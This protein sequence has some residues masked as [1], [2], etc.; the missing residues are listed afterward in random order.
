MNH[1]KLACIACLLLIT[2]AV[3][4]QQTPVIS[5]TL[6]SGSEGKFESAPDTALVQF[7]ISLQ[8]ARLQD[9]YAQARESAARIRQIIR[10]NGLA[11]GDA[12]IGSF[13]MTPVYQWNAK[14]K[15]IGFQVNSS[16]VVKVHEFEKLGP[17]SD[18]FS[19]LDTSDGFSISFTLRNIE[20]AK[21]KAIEDGYRKA[22]SNAE[23]LAQAGGRKL[24][25]MSYASVDASEFI[26]QPRPVIMKAQLL[27]GHTEPAP[28]QGFTPA[29]IIITAH[30]NV[31]FQLE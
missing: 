10:D 19:Q 13:T 17:L 9:A 15:L 3:A 18:G 12:E 25:A 21:M 16:V 29:K 28:I 5:E 14:H 31:L 11:P 4:A 2:T 8:Q 26:P 24:G 22:R 7:S 27:T 20:S 23:V 6:W 1:L 30:V